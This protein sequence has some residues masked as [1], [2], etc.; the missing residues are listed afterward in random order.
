MRWSATHW[1][2]RLVQA[3]PRGTRAAC[4]ALQAAWAGLPWYGQLALKLLHERAQGR[5]SQ[6]ADYLEVLPSARDVDLPVL[7]PEEA[8]A[9]LQYPHL[10]L[11]VRPHERMHGQC[12]RM[13]QARPTR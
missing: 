4:T 1:S 12:V 3:P 2:L 11:Q 13:E 5:A 7:W 6:Y 9:A 8:L 10:G